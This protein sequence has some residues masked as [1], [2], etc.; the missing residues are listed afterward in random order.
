MFEDDKEGKVIIDIFC[1]KEY[2]EDDKL[3]ESD[4][5]IKFIYNLFKLLINMNLI[6]KE[7]FFMVEEDFNKGVGVVEFFYMKDIYVE[8]N[9]VK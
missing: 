3:F 2:L 1:V 6:E 9:K 5:Y 7:I 4:K 8:V